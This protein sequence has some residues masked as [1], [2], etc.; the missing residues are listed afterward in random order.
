[1]PDARPS[2]TVD[3][4]TPSVTGTGG[5]ERLR[6]V[7]D[8]IRKNRAGFRACFDRWGSKHPGVGGTVTLTF[9]LDPDGSFDNGDA[10]SQGFDA[11]EVLD[12]IIGYAHSLHYPASSSGKYTRFT[13]PFDFKPTQPR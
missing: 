4:K 1:L 12:C 6:P 11:P 7:T 3:D 8:L 13:Y 5:S 9:Y 10:D 2:A